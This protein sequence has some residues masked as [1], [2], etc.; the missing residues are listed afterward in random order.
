MKRFLVTGSSSGIGAALR[1]RLLADGHEV[2]GCSRRAGEFAHERYVGL[3]A[4]LTDL[5]AQSELFWNL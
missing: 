1:D 3:N 2:I 4:D 5:K